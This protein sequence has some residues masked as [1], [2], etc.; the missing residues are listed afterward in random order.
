MLSAHGYAIWL[1][2]AQCLACENE[3]HLIPP[4]FWNLSK[5][6]E[7]CTIHYMDSVSSVNI[8]NT[9]SSEAH[10]TLVLSPRVG[11]TSRTESCTIGIFTLQRNGTH[12]N[13][14]LS[15]KYEK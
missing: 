9:Y 8:G 13:N 7:R 14:M 6:E 4:A 12:N 10:Q 11:R 15:N 5:K 2:V 3:K 1:L